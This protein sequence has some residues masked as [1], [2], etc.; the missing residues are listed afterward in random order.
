ML[1]GGYYHCPAYQATANVSR[2][3]P[4]GRHSFPLDLPS[5]LQWPPH[6]PSQCRI[7][8]PP[9]PDICQPPFYCSPAKQRSVSA[10]NLPWRQSPVALNHGSQS[11][12]APSQPVFVC[13]RSRGPGNHWDFRKPLNLLNWEEPQGDPHLGTP[14]HI[15]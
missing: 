10:F 1:K 4:R 8:C 7:S 3:G 5:C 9:V 2:L 11:V 6:T 15:H 14:F 12:L 13:L